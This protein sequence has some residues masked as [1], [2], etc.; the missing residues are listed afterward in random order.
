VVLVIFLMFSILLLVFQYKPVQTWAAK[1]AAAYLSKKMHTKVGIAG[2]YLKPFTSVGIDSL[3]VLD[4]QKDT[5]ISLPKVTVGINGF[6]LFNSLTSR[7]IDFSQ[8]K[9]DNANIYLKKYKD[10]TTNLSSIIKYF[11][12]P[13]NPKNVKPSKPWQIKFDKITLNNMHFRY[14]DYLVD[15][16]M[17]QI[18]FDDLD[19]ANFS[20]VITDMDIKNHLFKGG[21]HNLTLRETKSGFYLKNLS[22]NATIDTNQILMQNLL[23]LTP[24][25]RIQNYLHMK[26][27]SF[28]DFDDVEDK[29]YFDGDFKSAQVASKDIGYFADLSKTRFDVGLDGRIKG[30]INNLS[31]K[32]LLITA[33]QATYVRGDF[34]LR[35]LPDWRNTLMEL[36]FQQIA[37]NKKDLDYLISN[38]SGDPKS[39]AP[40]I[41][42]KFGNINFT[43]RFTGLQNDFV[44][45]GTFKTKLGRFDSDINLKL[46]KNDIP[47]Y[48]GKVSADNFNLGGL[49]D[50]GDMGRTTFKADVKGSGDDLKNLDVAANAKLAYI[51]YKGYHYNNVAVNGTFVKELFSGKVGINDKNIKLDA[52][53]SIDLKPKLPVYNFAANIQNAQLHTLKILK[54]T[55]TLTAQI[56]SNVSG[57]D[58]KNLSGHILVSPIRIVDPR[59]NFLVDSIDLSIN[60]SDTARYVQLKSDIADASIKGKFDLATLPSY[61]KSIVKKYIPSLKTTITT[62]KPEQFQFNLTLKKL[63]PVLVMLDPNIKVPDQGTF[64]GEFNSANKT[65]TLNGYVKT[66]QYG[67]TVFHDLIIDESTTDQQLGVNV[68]LSKINITDSLFIKNIDISNVLRK[69]SLNFNI[70]LADKDA[71][72]QLDLYGLVEFGRDTTAKLKLLP[73][74]I[75][76]QRRD[77]RLQQQA[78][79]RLLGG[80]TEISN[81]A[82]S[83]GNQIVKIDGFISDDPAD[84]LKVNFS[85]FGMDNFDQLTKVSGFYMR[86]SLNGDV[87]LSAITKTPGVDAQLGIDSLSMNNTLVGNVKL[88]SIIDNGRSEAQVKMTVNNHGEETMNIGGTYSMAKDAGDRALDFGINMDHAETIIFGPFIRD[89]VSDP[90]GNISSNLKLTGSVSKPQLNGDITFNN[91]GVTVNYLKTA[92][93]IN[94][95]V[96]VKGSVINLDNLVLKDGHGGQGIVKG[97]VDLNDLGDPDIEASVNA[98]KLLALNTKFKDN[99]LYY[100]TAYATGDFSFSGP[101]DNMSINIKAKTEA[102]TVFNIP[103]N[104]SST[105]GDYD[106]VKFVSH[107]DTT[108]KVAVDSS[109]FNGVTLNMDLSADEKTTVKITTDY[110][111]LEGNGVTN[112]L[113]LNIT[114]LGDFEMFGD[115]LISSGKFEFTAKNFISKNFTVNQG[116]TIRWT[117]NP[118]NASINLDAIYEVRTEVANLYDAAGLAAP[119]GNELVLVQ[120]ELIL[121]KS[122]LLPNIDFDFN[123]PTDPS[124]K[125]DLGTYLNDYNNRS[126]QALSIIVR[127]EFASGTPGSLTNQVASTA[128]EAVSEFAFNKL[129]ALISQS[130][131]KNFDLNLRSFND[132]SATIK[133][134]NQ[135]LTLNGSLF[136]NTGSNNLFNNPSTNLFNSNFNDITKDFEAQYL[137]RKNG[138]LT[139]RYSYRLLNSTTLND[140]NQLSLQYVN[141]VGLVY[142]RDF[143]TFGEF[144]RN[145]F[146]Q[147]KKDNPPMQAPIP[148]PTPPAN[149]G[150]ATQPQPPTNSNP[151]P[152]SNPTNKPDGGG[153]SGDDDD[154]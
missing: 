142:Q 39:V 97:T 69:D 68:S 96:N 33:G 46:G 123:F 64:F 82:L 53:G 34:Q 119:K 27:K 147:K 61:F 14:K 153:S 38:F 89:L 31:A 9:L 43:G 128:G 50:V 106:F 130:N 80:K 105:V 85:K 83:N 146:G 58:L 112:N 44:A 117:G 45:Y 125:D 6:T 126:M 52:N 134:L 18:N 47:S 139:A 91:T 135:R 129:N 133:L 25:T 137:L 79:I 138:D 145:F 107:N 98:Q 3:Y 22:A 86:G 104:T 143:D 15:T 8:I 87:V 115:Y 36:N 19:V 56:R 151:T 113:K 49:I 10:S 65:A 29:V 16:L 101:V 72:N 62:P 102:G 154:D 111:V 24:Q 149:T 23:I 11:N 1:K 35:G 13:G 109:S 144:F 12:T 37:T 110:G 114:S 124:I 99:H 131:I 63:D 152:T 74:D 88:Q 120:A 57:D 26:F 92:Y 150:G 75:I 100:G 60:R 141:G 122:L 67:K 41:I 28:D 132:A 17:N 5:L 40:A 78:R 140:I 59:N 95:K 93:T 118:A 2:L 70:K 73:S 42:S 108:R 90:K 121:T 55:I 32:N 103:L 94:D 76:I 148:A 7:Y 66:I 54:D 51:D 77:W 21:I 84:K 71:T 4:K 136:S 30:F 116:G 127:R 20:T 81:F 48:S